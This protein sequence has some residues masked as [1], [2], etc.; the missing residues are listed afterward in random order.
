MKTRLAGLI[1]A[2][3][4]ASAGC[5]T[6]VPLDAAAPPVVHPRRPERVL[7][8]VDDALRRA[9]HRASRGRKTWVYPLGE[10]LPAL[11]ERTLSGAFLLVAVAPDDASGDAFDLV[12]RPEL[13]RFAAAVPPGVH[14]PTPTAVEIAWHVRDVRTGGT[15]RLA[16]AATDEPATDREVEIDRRLPPLE[17]PRP[18]TTSGRTTVQVVEAPGYERLA[19]RDATKAILHAVDALDQ[20]LRRE[21]LG[22]P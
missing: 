20:A 8:V 18:R 3:A 21:V 11:F 2:V 15:F 14:L 1:A 9:S 17:S 16:A 6:R 4:A 12:V 13:V 5:A 10:A 22:S 7:L 19:A